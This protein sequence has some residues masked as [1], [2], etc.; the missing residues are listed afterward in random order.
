MVHASPAADG[1]KEVILEE[2]ERRE[3]RSGTGG[4]E[5]RNER[6]DEG[7]KRDRY[8][9]TYTR[10]CAAAVLWKESRL[11]LSLSCVCRKLANECQ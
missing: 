4:G 11:V 8:A 1:E 7:R 5:E 6:R 3:I 9:R 10:V 2:R